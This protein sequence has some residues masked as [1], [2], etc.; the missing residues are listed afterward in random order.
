MIKGSPPP[1]PLVKGLTEPELF[2]LLDLELRAHY[3][4]ER[5]V[6][7]HVS[8]KSARLLQKKAIDPQALWYG[9]W[10]KKPITQAIPGPVCAKWINAKVGWGVFAEKSIE[11]DDYISC[12][13]GQIRLARM[14]PINRYCFSFPLIAAPF[15]FF[16]GNWT[17][18][19]QNCGNISRFINHSDTPNCESLLAFLSP[20][21]YIVIRASRDIAKGEQL[22]YDYGPNYWRHLEKQP[23]N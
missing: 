15:A 5:Q 6:A 12:Y 8:K 11:K 14:S 19:A 20:W 22:F 9:Q 4:Y 1:L 16:R 7:E 17:I 13:L 2:A 18:D 10:Y 23:L 3:K 21:P